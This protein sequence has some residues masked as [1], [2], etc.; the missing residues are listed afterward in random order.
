[1]VSGKPQDAPCET[2]VFTV[3]DRQD[4]LKGG[5]R[6]VADTERNTGQILLL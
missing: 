3:R 1:M 4:L 6:V 2:A 5:D